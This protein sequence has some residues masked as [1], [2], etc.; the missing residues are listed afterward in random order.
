MNVEAPVS[1]EL[2]KLAALYLAGAPAIAGGADSICDSNRIDRAVPL[3]PSSAPSSRHSR[4]PRR[5]LQLE[6]FARHC[7]KRLCLLAASSCTQSS[8][9][10]SLTWMR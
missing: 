8:S 2:R 5:A 3:S 1:S 10:S 7:S 9:A 4:T 6:A